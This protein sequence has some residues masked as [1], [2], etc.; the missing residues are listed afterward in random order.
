MSYMHTGWLLFTTMFFVCWYIRWM[1]VDEQE[2]V[3]FLRSMLDDQHRKNRRLE[4]EMRELRTF[5]ES[6]N[7]RRS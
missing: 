1:W 2:R 7:D 5:M 4:C 6:D 3:A